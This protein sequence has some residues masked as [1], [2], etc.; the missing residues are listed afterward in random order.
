MYH[1]FNYPA[2]LMS[3][4]RTTWQVEDVL[5]QGAD[6]DFTR[7]FMPEAL[8]AVSLV[9]G[10]S[11]SEALT[12]NHIRGHEY[13]AIFGL[14]EE[15][16]LP[17]VLDHILQD[18]AGDDRVRALLKFASEEAKHIQLFKGFEALF[19]ASFASPCAMIGPSEAIGKHVLRHDPLSISLMILQIEWMTQSHYLDGVRDDAGIDS[20][21]ASLL[22]HHWIEECQ[23]AKLDTLLVEAL[24]ALRKPE[25]V[26][27]AVDGYLDIVSFFDDGFR[28]QATLNL[29]AFE[30]AIGRELDALTRQAFLGCQHQSLRWTYLGSGMTH[31][32]FRAT[33][34]DISAAALTRVDAAAVRFCRTFN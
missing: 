11:K 20:L 14:V 17:F 25:E 32:N 29:A 10:L 8:A 21:F 27:A 12:L 23:H 22:R 13:L 9:P 24:A 6:L 28:S 16:I 34:G 2:V 3:G 19:S 15:F 31:P 33:L 5:P 18:C 4:A 26:E 30:A 1:D 7:P